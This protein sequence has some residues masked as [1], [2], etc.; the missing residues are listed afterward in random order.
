MILAAST[1]MG[2]PQEKFDG[3]LREGDVI[4][5]AQGS[6]NIEEWIEAEECMLLQAEALHGTQCLTGKWKVENNDWAGEGRS[7]QL[8]CRP[9]E[10]STLSLRFKGVEF[11]V[12]GMRNSWNGPILWSL[13]DDASQGV[14]DLHIDSGH[15][16]QD[17]LLSLH[18][19]HPGEHEFRLQSMSSG[20]QKHNPF[21]QEWQ[22]W[23]DYFR[24]VGTI[25]DSR[26]GGVGGNNWKLID[27]S[28]FIGGK[29]V[30]IEAVGE[31]TGSFLGDGIEVTALCGP[32]QGR[33]TLAVDG[34]TTREVDLSRCE[35][36]VRGVINISGLGRGNNQ[37]GITHRYSL[38][39]GEGVCIVDRLKFTRVA[40]RKIGSYE[41]QSSAYI[42]GERLACVVEERFVYD[43]TT[44]TAQAV[45]SDGTILAESDDWILD[46][47]G[48]TPSKID[49]IRFVFSC[50]DFNRSPELEKVHLLHG[51]ID[52]DSLS[53][54]RFMIGGNPGTIKEAFEAIQNRLGN[55]AWLPKTGMFPTDKWN[56]HSK[57][58][59]FLNAV[60]LRK[61]GMPFMI[62]MRRGLGD[63][64]RPVQILEDWAQDTFPDI[65]TPVEIR[66]LRAIGGNGFMGL[67]MEEMDI[68]QVQGGLRAET[69]SEM[70]QLYPATGRHDARCAYEAEIAKYVNRY[71]GFG[72]R[73]LVNCGVTFQCATY[74]AGADMVIAELQ[75]H[76]VSNPVQLALLRGASH[77]FG[78]P[79]GAWTSLWWYL[80]IP[81]EDPA[82][83]SWQNPSTKYTNETG[84][85]PDEMCRSLYSAH[86]S[87]AQINVVQ[88]AIPLFTDFDRDGKW[89]L[90]RYG[91]AIRDF[92]ETVTTQPQ[93]LPQKRVAIMI[94][95]DSGWSPATLWQGFPSWTNS[96]YDRG[97]EI[98][99]VW[100][101]EKA[102]RP[103][104]M[105]LEVL[106]I[107]YPGFEFQGKQKYPGT[108]TDTPLGP[109]DIIESDISTEKLAA[110]RG[111]IIAGYFNPDASTVAKLKEFVRGGGWMAANASQFES[112]GKDC[113]LWGATYGRDIVKANG[114]VSVG[115]GTLL[116]KAMKL[117]PDR[118]GFTLR[119]PNLKSGL[120]AVTT[121][122][123][124]PLVIENSIGKGRVFLSMS[125]FDLTDAIISEATLLTSTERLFNEFIMQLNRG[126]VTVAWQKGLEYLPFDF[127]NGDTGIL[128][129]NHSDKPLFLAV[130]CN[131]NGIKR[132]Y[133][134]FDGKDYPLRT[135]LS[136]EVMTDVDIG[137]RGKAVVIFTRSTSSGDT[138]GAP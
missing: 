81:C 109:I 124:I 119:V 103:E 2:M 10:T 115:R 14:L 7:L 98:G 96:P 125:D 117:G 21:Q 47:S 137:P 27:G 17:R 68:S 40:V 84:Y 26:L 94:D 20:Y 23:L 57:V 104:V 38:T 29:A 127:G 36:G 45:S 11:E 74:R 85:T 73:A 110:Y 5:L 59:I 35:V 33:L 112:F 92:A 90:S 39:A 70:P 60:A 83:R 99:H 101:V 97:S 89:A 121:N 87:G 64:V 9:S 111:V 48:V 65:F 55:F 28:E 76:M 62:S 4:R 16:F 135:E 24:V 78:K 52:A 138:A 66:A 77:Q 49:R 114:A 41:I 126:H 86:Y 88:D 106:K 13:D 30:R 37:L 31:L 69:R 61:A 105:L 58:D 128:L 32:G 63:M 51:P 3:T 122:N 134:A 8:L 95:P 100:G 18:N 53:L 118:P 133:G 113:E 22:V 50:G 19:L 102:G 79:F 42:K 44:I 12:Y 54:P 25:N 131:M 120:V 67:L 56:R 116:S 72:L 130:F 75:E 129:M 46:L 136:G 43:G 123:N 108:F 91:S 6:K 71:H 1:A 107:I 34:V 132:I 82:I 93:P 15:I 80:K